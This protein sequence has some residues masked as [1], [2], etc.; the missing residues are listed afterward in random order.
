VKLSKEWVRAIVALLIIVCTYSLCAYVLYLI[1]LSNVDSVESAIIG[2]LLG[3]MLP[4]VKEIRRA[5]FGSQNDKKDVSA[6]P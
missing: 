6:P 4:E 5:Y 1:K 2:L 3:Q